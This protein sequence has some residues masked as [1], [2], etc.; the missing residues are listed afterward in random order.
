MKALVVLK[1]FTLNLHQ[2]QR[3]WTDIE[4]KC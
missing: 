2:E 3:S 4:P 1:S